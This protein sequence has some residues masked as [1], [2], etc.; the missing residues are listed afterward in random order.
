[1]T[2]HERKG[3]EIGEDRLPKKKKKHVGERARQ[4]WGEVKGRMGLSEPHLAHPQLR[5]W[6]R[7]VKFKAS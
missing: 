1:M 6:P 3:E 7:D 5:Q 4:V 2:K